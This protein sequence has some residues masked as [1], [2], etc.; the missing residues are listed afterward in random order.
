MLIV[1]DLDVALRR[2]ADRADPGWTYVTAAG[3][4]VTPEGLIVGGREGDRDSGSLLARKREIGQS[5]EQVGSLNRELDEARDAAQRAL[6]AG[7]A[8]KVEIA[9]VG[10]ER[11]GARDEAH[12]CEMEAQRLRDRRV[13]ADAEIERSSA[14]I[15]AGEENAAALRREVESLGGEL[16]ASDVHR[17]EQSS[18]LDEGEGALRQARQA[19]QIA[20]DEVAANRL[21]AARL[22]AEIDNLRAAESREKE[23]LEEMEVRIERLR[24]EMDDAAGTL[25]GLADEAGTIESALQAALADEQESAGRT[26]TMRAAM[27]EVKEEL[28]GLEERARAARRRHDAAREELHRLEMD[29][30]ELRTNQ[31]ALR[32]QIRQQHRIDLADAS[33]VDAAE[34]EAEDESAS[35]SAA[36]DDDGIDGDGEGDAAAA[37]ED[38]GARPSA[39]APEPAPIPDPTEFDELEDPDQRLDELRR[40]LDRLGQ[41]N[42]LAIEQHDE[43]RKRLDFL[44]EQR[45]DLFDPRDT[46]QETIDRI[47]TAAREAFTTTF[48]QIRSHFRELFTTLFTDGDADV[49]LEED[50]DPL[51]ASID[52]IARPGGKRPQKLSLLSSGEK[53]MT[54]IALLFSLFRV[55]PSPFCLLDEI[56]APLDDA[57]ILRF[58]TLLEKYTHDTQFLVIT[59][60]KRTMEAA[61]AIFGITMEEVG[62]SKI[63]SLRVDERRQIDEGALASLKGVSGAHLSTA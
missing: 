61:G 5:E 3:E 49:F 7:R 19:R 8:L 11:D 57:N 6:Q 10:A 20:E 54:A 56:D 31:G 2:L 25:E 32:E 17:S 48:A 55:R 22:E 47:N 43:E 1:D 52:I 28:R 60:N 42:V 29:A 23:R 34:H 30:V 18:A 14:A 26:D 53:T 36:G 39:D 21:A 15:A 44:L 4:V 16:E 33:A 45:Q 35:M 50:V 40:A 63:L 24:A 51:D 37:G 9:E 38:E 62:V 59:H 12:R 41:V 58:V 27:S 13:A 46:L